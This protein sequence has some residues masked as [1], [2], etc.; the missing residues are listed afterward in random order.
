MIVKTNKASR[1]TVLTE[2]PTNDMMIAQNWSI[3]QSKTGITKMLACVAP[4]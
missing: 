3:I 1:E 2:K 4:N